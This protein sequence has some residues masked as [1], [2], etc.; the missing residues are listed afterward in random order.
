GRSG[1]QRMAVAHAPGPPG[2]HPSK[3]RHGGGAVRNGHQEIS[4]PEAPWRSRFSTSNA[5]FI[6]LC[7][8]KNGTHDASPIGCGTRLRADVSEQSTYMLTVM[9][10][11]CYWAVAAKGDVWNEDSLG[12]RRDGGIGIGDRRGAAAA[13]LSRDHLSSRHP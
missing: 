1:T 12:H 4:L 5:P 6:S 2:Q 7:R 13:R 3:A 9:E 11:R 10:A 8:G